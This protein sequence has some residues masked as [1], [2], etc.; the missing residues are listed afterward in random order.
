MDSRIMIR[1]YQEADY[2]QV[3]NICI[4]TAFDPLFQQ[5]EMQELLLTAFCDYYIEKEPQNCF[6]ASGIEKIAG[7][8]L[9]TENS[10]RWAELFR[11]EYIPENSPA[12]AFYEGLTGT[13]LRY[14]DE[15]PAHLHIDILPEYQRQ[16]I[17]FRLID[18][19]LAHLKIKGVPGL[20]LSVASDNDKGIHFYKKYGFKVLERTGQEIVMG[21]H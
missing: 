13:P 6:V 16:G 10:K 12:K 19:L 2:T 3:Q 9:C 4:A 14:A 17:G 8:I 11:K 18:A 15:Y 20:M 1:P 5:Q 21:I 7:Y